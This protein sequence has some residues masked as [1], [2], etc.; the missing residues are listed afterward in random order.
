MIPDNAWGLCLTAAAGTEL[1]TPYS[2]ADHR[3]FLQAKGVYVP[4]DF[5][6]HAA[7]LDQAFAHR[8]I[9]SATATRRCM[10]RVSVPSVGVRLSPPLA[11]KALVSHYLTN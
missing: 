4:K 3:N 9:F 1:A 2:P 8:R 5:I 11:V 7:S 6:H 10:D